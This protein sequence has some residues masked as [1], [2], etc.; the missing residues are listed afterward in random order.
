MRPLRLTLDGFGPYA[1]R[2]EVDFA[3][4]GPHRLF[5][6]CGPTGAGKTS[7]LDAICFA[8]FGESSGDE[9][10]P[11]HLRSLH[12]ALDRPTEVTFDFAQ[13]GRRWRIRRQP[14]WERP[15]QRGEGTMKQATRVALWE[16]SGDVAGPPTERQSEVAARIQALLG[17][18]A[19]EFRQVVL[20]PQGRFRE[21]LTAEPKQR[22]EILRTLFRTALYARIQ[23][24]LRDGANRARGV[25]RD[26][27]TRLRTLL[28]QAGGATTV[29]AQ[30]VR[31]GLSLARDA[32]EVER[33]AAE[34]AEAAAR[35]VAYAGRDADRKR[36]AAAEAATALAAQRAREPEIDADRA[37]LEAARR[38]DRLRGLLAAADAARDTAQ[39]MAKAEAAAQQ[40]LAEACGQLAQAEGAL[41][42][43]ATR[44]QAIAT[45][46]TESQRLAALAAL[47]V[48]AEKAAQEATRCEAAAKQ[49]AATLSMA[50]RA[51]I[52]ARAAVE[53]A[54][55]ALA[56]QDALAAQRPH[57]ALL[58]DEAAR[59]LAAAE[60]LAKTLAALGKATTLHGK[61]QGSLAAAREVAE[62]ARLAREVASA[63]LSANH[64]AAL[65]QTLLPGDPCPVCGS[66]HH[67]APARLHDG[68]L[69]DLAAAAQAETLAQ[70]QLDDA[71]SGA[72]QAETAL[73]LA[74]QAEVA[75]RS[76]LGDGAPDRAGLEA[77]LERAAGDLAEAQRAEAAL[78]AS[79]VALNVARAKT[80]TAEAALHTAKQESDAARLALATAAATRDERRRPLPDGAADAA[81]L[82]A[83]AEAMAR[84]A[85]DVS[86]ALQ[87]DRDARSAALA[88]RASGEAAAARAAEDARKAAEIRQTATDALA[89]AGRREGFAD[90]RALR[91]SLLGAAAQDALAQ[92]IEAFR[93]DLATAADRAASTAR[94][95]ADLAAP[96]LA[97]LDAA[98]EAA[99]ARRTSA[100]EIAARA[101]EKLA[102]QDALLAEIATAAMA[103]D[104]ALADHALR[105]N[106]ADLAA[107]GGTG[108]NFEGY[109]LSGL[110]DEALEAANRRLAPM[111]GGRYAIR[112]REE[113]DRA[114]AAAGLDIEVVDRWNMQPRPAAT[115]SGGEG[116]CASLALALGLSETVAAHAGARQLDALFVDEGFGSL[117]PETL[118][119]AIGVLEGLQAGDRMVGVI[120]HVAEMRE[121]IPARLEVTPGRAGSGLAFRFG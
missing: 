16:M 73:R 70:R 56:A 61:R 116:F 89:E 95:A 109:V 6:I 33:L 72:Q 71:V 14:E 68:V 82:R 52:A 75:A 63:A 121:R 43:A 77:A 88:D 60:T 10:R 81:T 76:A 46:Q 8:L 84:Q 22:Q 106:L 114:N 98:L 105:Q 35:G 102:T 12:A 1:A 91:D 100:A 59:R 113:R 87:K 93:R 21:V 31:D 34:Q 99:T 90:A 7:L 86:T 92:A 30:A 2:Q 41:A 58:Q 32:A 65:A 17:L 5:L 42:D 39:A 40:R 115:L 45:A 47:A 80:V 64:A 110:L 119:T 85:R 103:R 25:T 36:K 3:A 83:R 29:E 101:V 57:R 54:A 53:G 74:E 62:A 94:D 44:E 48:E 96:D 112:R 66:A 51:V 97:A 69:P 38:A 50:E 20:L 79:R 27:E 11:G 55:A 37:R 111:L 118:D 104:V 28:G 9:R 18:S 4:L 49:A 117:D 13:A 107:G 23:A 120:S 108:L 78:P 26:A 15:R 24:E 67:P 19:A